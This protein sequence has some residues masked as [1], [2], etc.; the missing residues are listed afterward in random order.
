MTEPILESVAFSEDN[1]T[2]MLS[3]YDINSKRSLYNLGN[4]KIK[5]SSASLERCSTNDSNDTS[6]DLTC[7]FE[8]KKKLNFLE[9]RSNHNA[10]I[11]FA[12]NSDSVK[13]GIL[14]QENYLYIK[15]SRLLNLLHCFMRICCIPKTYPKFINHHFNILYCT[16][17]KLLL[18][19][20][21]LL[22]K[23]EEP[24]GSFTDK[25]Y[26]STYVEL[27]KIPIQFHGG[28]EYY[29]KESN[30]KS[31]RE[32]EENQLIWNQRIRESAEHTKGE[33]PYSGFEE[34][35]DKGEKK[36]IIENNRVH[37][38][39]NRIDFSNMYDN[40]TMN[41]FN[42]ML[43]KMNQ[44]EKSIS[45]FDVIINKF[46][47]KK[48]MVKENV[49]TLLMNINKSYNIKYVDMIN[50]FKNDESLKNLNERF[51]LE[52]LKNQLENEQKYSNRLD[53]SNNI[54][55]IVE[56]RILLKFPSS[57]MKTKEEEHIRLVKN[58]E[59][60][61]QQQQKK[62]Q[63]Q[64]DR[65]VESHKY[66][67]TNALIEKI[68]LIHDIQKEH[69]ME[70]ENDKNN[71]LLHGEYPKSVL[72]QIKEKLSREIDY[73]KEKE[74]YEK[75]IRRQNNVHTVDSIYNFL[76]FNIFIP[77]DNI[78][79]DFVENGND[80]FLNKLKK[81]D[82]CAYVRLVDKFD[83]MYRTINEFKT[84]VKRNKMQSESSY[85]CSEYH[86]HHHHVAGARGLRGSFNEYHGKG[87][88]GRRCLKNCNCKKIKKKKRGKKGKKVDVPKAKRGRPAED[89]EKKKK[90][91][92]EK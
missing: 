9:N 73:D 65:T 72:E 68:K 79:T 1:H 37:Y 88:R 62:K 2:E 52:I 89:K 91:K 63:Q 83:R 7:L 82:K 5:E 41:F 86:H 25:D 43:S 80:F 58:D 20:E 81:T 39:M 55:K 3:S 4:S 84:V 45:N 19:Y 49:F 51:I 59:E 16:D 17:I 61:E 26:Y 34:M 70:I 29:G 56:D 36:S 13:E 54:T 42:Y 33:K 76:R 10:K 69:V 53:I 12:N 35:N 71:L 74:E 90:T 14:N 40:V 30:G 67:S 48:E 38:E 15:K 21:C 60:V 11:E 87:R 23:F 44:T 18:Q 46:L 8:H 66:D 22:Q 57:F 78:Y 32:K 75:E 50:Q 47:E 77:S 31:F 24:D 64:E 85:S 28:V 6:D 27:N 92:I